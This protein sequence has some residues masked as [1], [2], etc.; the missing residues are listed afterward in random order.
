MSKVQVDYVAFTGVTLTD[1]FADNQKVLA[2]KY[3]PN[4]HLDLSYTPK[5]GQT[6]RYLMVLIEVSNDEGTT[7]FPIT[8]KAN[9]TTSIKVYDNLFIHFPGDE[10]STGGVELTGNDDQVIIG[11]HVKISVKESGSGNY[12]VCTMR[13]TLSNPN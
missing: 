9:L 1:D 10:T 4:L 6:N 8:T 13:A 5:A 12:G 7:Y 3:L 2:C 11:D